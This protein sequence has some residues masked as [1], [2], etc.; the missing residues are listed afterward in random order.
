MCEECGG[1]EGVDGGV[2]GGSGAFCDG[3][4]GRRRLPVGWDLRLELLH[5]PIQ[6]H[7][8]KSHTQ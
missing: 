2:G 3:E 5:P 8:Y 6:T 4:G 1:R 7:T